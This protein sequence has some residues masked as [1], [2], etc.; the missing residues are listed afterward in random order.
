MIRQTGTAIIL[1]TALIAILTVSMLKPTTNPVATSTRVPVKSQQGEVTLPSYDSYALST[2]WAGTVCQLNA[3]GNYK[4]YHDGFN[5]HGL[6][7]DRDSGNHPFNCDDSDAILTT[8]PAELQSEIT[9]HWNGLYSTEQGF[10]SHE[11]SKHGTCWNPE[12]GNRSEMSPAV[13]KLLEA[14]DEDTKDPATYLRLA[15]HLGTKYNHY[16]T[17]AKHGI[18][19]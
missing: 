11:W 18:L 4:G 7:P 2:E 12:L 9:T 6:W 1:S 14:A 8:L 15:L 17:L 13:V 16:E 5:L 3:C 19:P 10:I